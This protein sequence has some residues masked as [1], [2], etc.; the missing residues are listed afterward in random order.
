M[1]T[2]I[3]TGAAGN[4]GSAA[5][6]KFLSAGYQVVATV[7]SEKEKSSMSSNEHLAVKIVDLSNEKEAEQFVSASISEYK[8]IDAALMI[9]GGYAPGD[10]IQTSGKE[11][12]KQFSLNFHTAFF[13]SRKLFEHMMENNSGRLIFV[14]ARPGLDSNAGKSSIAYAL[15]KS[16][17]FKW[18]ELLN[19]SAKKK[20]VTA[21]VF[22]PS[23]IDTS[24]NRQSMPDA[25]PSDWVKAEQIA[26]L[27]EMVCSEKGMPLRETIL[28]VYN[29]A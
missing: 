8:K 15:S 12:E 6:G 26:E 19:A 25:N 4:L 22:V 20:N 27:M 13:L 10:V 16:L 21:T 28:K 23:T 17:I 18:A 7:I 3:I 2:V 24:Q 14:G 29:N 5:V 9:A 11:L 1:K